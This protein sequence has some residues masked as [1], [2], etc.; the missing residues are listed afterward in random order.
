MNFILG[1][2]GMII[3]LYFGTGYLPIAEDNRMKV[4]IYGGIALTILGAI[5]QYMG[6][7]KPTGGPSKKA[8]KQPVKEKSNVPLGRFTCGAHSDSLTETIGGRQNIYCRLV[9]GYIDAKDDI[10]SRIIDITSFTVAHTPDGEIVPCY[11]SAFCELRQAKRNF[12]A[13]RIIECNT[14]EGAEVTDLMGTLMAAPQSM[15]F[16]GK[17]TILK[18]LQIGTMDI[19]YQFRAP[20][21]RRVTITP[22]KA[23]YQ[24]MTV[25]QMRTKTLV[26][27][28]G[29][30]EDKAELQRFRIARLRAAWLPD[31]QTPI[32]DLAS[33]LLET[34]KPL[35]DS[36]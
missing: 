28:E 31:G 12:R 24:E 29:F 5:G 10:T 18:P 30:T 25:G 27:I 26:F 19:E 23:A 11:L 13:D 1:T 7:A 21:F 6:K 33:Y 32:T 2:V 16:E 15:R 36:Q 9:I 20:N 8:I 14:A 3:L 4:A 35:G 22:T 17:T 34:P